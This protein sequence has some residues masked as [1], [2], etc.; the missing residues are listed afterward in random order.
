VAFQIQEYM[1]DHPPVLVYYY[2]DEFYAFRPA[3]YDGW[4]ESPGSGI[5]H[6]WSLLPPESRGITARAPAEVK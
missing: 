1:L 2:P 6:K 3:A 4:V 5:V